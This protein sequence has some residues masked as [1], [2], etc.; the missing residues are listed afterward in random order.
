M[1]GKSRPLCYFH[2]DQKFKDDISDERI[3]A[4]KAK[5]RRL[6]AIAAMKGLA[7]MPANDIITAIDGNANVEGMVSK[8]HREIDI[9]HL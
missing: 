3:D 1:C 6:V 7:E 4:K 9:Y 8:T 5:D 2:S